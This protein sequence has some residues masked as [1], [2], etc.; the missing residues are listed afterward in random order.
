MTELPYQSERISQLLLERYNL[1]ELDAG[2]RRQVE[3]LLRTDTGTAA[4]LE[5]LKD[6]DREIRAAYPPEKAFPASGAPGLCGAPERRVRFAFRVFPV[7]AALG[8]LAACAAA[9][10]FFSLTL[11]HGHS[12]GRDSDA[13]TDRVKGGTELRVYLK[14]GET[15]L[16]ENAVLHAGNTVQLAYTSGKS[17]YGV[18]FSIDGRKV[19]TLHYP[20]RSG[21]STALVQGKR[22]ALEEAYTLDDA[23]FCEIFFFVSSG[24]PVDVASVL[25]N[26]EILAGDPGTALARGTGVFSEYELETV[27]IGKE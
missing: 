19:V 7:R 21:G 17:R 9:A 15:P 12:S 11:F 14:P 26:A 22:T 27:Y 8:A 23:P 5:K 1:G 18:I 25:R 24:S 10:L 13:L 4:R 3:V 20:Y 16:G 2:E 6:Q